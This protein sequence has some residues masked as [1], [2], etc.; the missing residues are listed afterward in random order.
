MT[1]PRLPYDN[2]RCAG[3]LCPRRETCLRYTAEPPPDGRDVPQMVSFLE[4]GTCQY[5]IDNRR[6]PRP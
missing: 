3:H 6:E 5:W 1:A 4:N 2:H